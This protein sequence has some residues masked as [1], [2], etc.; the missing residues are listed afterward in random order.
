MIKRIIHFFETIE[1]PRLKEKTV[2]KLFNEGYETPES[3][4]KASVKDFVKVKGIGQKTG[5][6]FYNTIRSA[7]VNTPPDRFIEAS[8]TFESGIGRTLLKLLFKNI[9][10]ILD[11][12]EEEIRKYFKTHKIPG[13]GAKRIE[14]VATGIPKFRDY[15]NS[16][17]KSDIEQ[18]INNYL[19]KIKKIKEEGYN[20]L[21][22]NNTFVL[23]NMPFT[24]DYELEDYIYD[25][26]GQFA[27]VVPVYF[28]QEFSERYHIPL[29]RFEK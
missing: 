24:T 29:K 13:F 2:E 11:L 9:P 14:N 18:S 21:I 15:L 22:S 20:P 16:F 25:N 17:A 7:M 3:I 6:L 1:V 26:N 12:S 28:L 4:I 23:T 8:T 19:N 10:N 27:D 5:E